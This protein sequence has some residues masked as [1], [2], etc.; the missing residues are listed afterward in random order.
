MGVMYNFLLCLFLL[1]QTSTAQINEGYFRY[2]HVEWR[3]VVTSN[4]SQYIV[5]FSLKLGS[6]DI[7]NNK[8]LGDVYDFAGNVFRFGDGSTASLAAPIVEY[9]VVSG[10]QP[11]FYTNPILTHEYSGPGPWYAEVESGQYARDATLE[12]ND[13]KKF[14]LRS[15]VDLANGNNHS[16]VITEPIS[17][18]FYWNQTDV[19]LVAYDP[20]GDTVTFRLSTSFELGDPANATLLGLTQIQAQPYQLTVG[21]N[22][23]TISWTKA[24]DLPPGKYQLQ[25]M[26]MDGQGGEV[27]IDFI[28][29]NTPLYNLRPVIGGG[30]TPVPSSNPN[31]EN[32]LVNQPIIFEVQA[33]DPTEAIA[34]IQ[35]IETVNQMGRN[36]TL[37]TLNATCG[38]QAF[39]YTPTSVGLDRHCFYAYD[40]VGTVSQVYCFFHNITARS[41]VYTLWQAPTKQMTGWPLEVWFTGHY[42]S[43]LDRVH[44]IL[45][46]QNCSD[47]PDDAG[48]QVE[49]AYDPIYRIANGPTLNYRRTKHENLVAG[50]VGYNK[51]CYK[52]N[53][54][55]AYGT[56]L[57]WTTV[58]MNPPPFEI[59]DTGPYRVTTLVGCPL[60]DKAFRY[61]IDG[62]DLVRFDRVKFLTP[63]VPPPFIS[64]I[65]CKD[66]TDTDGTM[67]RDF[68]VLDG[69]APGFVTGAE[70]VEFPWKHSVSDVGQYFCYKPY[71]KPWRMIKYIKPLATSGVFG[72]GGTN[73]ISQGNVNITLNGLGLLPD[74]KFAAYQYTPNEDCSAM[75]GNN[76]NLTNVFA[77]GQNVTDT[78]FFNI[79]GETYPGINLV[80]LC[81][82]SN[83]SACKIA[84][85]N[86]RDQG[87][88]YKG[89]P[90]PLTTTRL[91]PYVDYEPFQAYVNE[92]MIYEFTGYVPFGYILND[93]CHTTEEMEEN[94]ETC[95]GFEVKVAEHGSCTGNA[96]GGEAKFMGKDRRVIFRLEEVGLFRFCVKHRIDWEPVARGVSIIAVPPLSNQT[97][98]YGYVNCDA[99]LS[100]YTPHLTCGC[101]LGGYPSEYVDVPTSHPV[102]AALS[103]SL[104]FNQGCCSIPSAS[105]IHMG[106]DVKN[107]VSRPWGYCQ[108][109][110]VQVPFPY[111]PYECAAETPK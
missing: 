94:C 15:R 86:L 110:P 24:K 30:N 105:R 17:Q 111:P 65:N 27:P 62:I 70:I 14:R 42:L 9:N 97:A 55:T 41:Y 82:L 35:A 26:Y 28:L 33:C 100:E 34:S 95:K 93:P 13:R 72:I 22:N 63:S 66:L 25:I 16:P 48:F 90:D 12:D 8:A 38:V 53:A 51:W 80:S 104:N 32:F 84:D 44:H 109:T 46:T 98:F 76:S 59:T 56:N 102:S 23:G 45:D 36:G 75:F 85:V 2:G 81:Y 71:L 107:G 19:Q 7:F 3:R 21:L 29:E 83:N 49:L 11:W 106:V 108:H 96:K 68:P 37:T 103:S 74:D 54:G 39:N 78:P 61:I 60:Y 18:T 10:G 73:Q 50:Q 58:E 91:Y 6:N 92:S 47:L 101:F 1:V 88:G 99:Y 52:M 87:Y 20:D 5:Q 4:T 40:A 77:P 89:I 64:T 79:S 67:I 69:L 43:P 57:S 31:E